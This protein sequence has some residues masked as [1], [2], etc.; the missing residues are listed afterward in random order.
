MCPERGDQ[1]RPDCPPPESAHGS[2]AHDS[3]PARREPDRGALPRT[4]RRQAAATLGRVMLGSTG[5][6]GPMVVV[7][8]ARL[9]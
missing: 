7:I 8:E 1:P 5:I 2:T 4:R 3:A 6:P 9:R